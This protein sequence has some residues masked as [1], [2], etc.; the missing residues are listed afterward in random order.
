MTD[1]LQQPLDL[2]C[3]VSVPNR[4]AKAAMTEGLATS[5][6]VATPE[7]EQLY[8]LWSDGGAG[9]LLSGN[10]QVDAAHLERP[11]NVVIER[12]PDAAMAKALASWASAA[13]RNGNHFWGQISHAGRQTQKMVNPHP[14]APSAIKLD[15]P[16][17]QFGVPVPLTTAEIAD[18]VGRF[19]TC[20][21]ALQVAGFTGVQVHAAHGYLLSQFLSPLS[22]LRDDEYGGNLANRARILLEIISE[23]RDAVGPGF[24]VA[25]KLN[26]ADF[27]K[28]GFDF[29]DSLQV[30]GWLEQAG[31][32]LIEISGG[33]YEQPKLLGVEGIEEE[34]SQTVAESTL[35][36]EAY[37]VDFAKAMQAK[38]AIPLMVTGGFRRRDIMTQCLT[39][40]DV[41]LIGIGRPM[42]VLTDAPARIFGGLD[43]L[44]RY[45]AQLSLLPPWLSG[46]N[47]LKTLRVMGTFAVQYWF[48]AQ[49]DLLG[50]TGKADPG[51]S[52]MQATR[53]M[54]ALQKKQLADR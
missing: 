46:L 5:A 43:T 38:V 2:P 28:G 22:N 29:E 19:G 31:V 30:A 40:G 45:E 36:R 42:C 8:G 32:D 1:L 26:S 13:T 11:G 12:E 23:V 14:K 21:R 15:L 44:P 18:I 39:A 41:D 6:G 24:P 47:R 48:Y 52:V 25:V 27:Q 50:T 7:L 17:G 54:M 34:E 49:L 20:A 3:G 16:G 51:L 4:L 53:R 10:I 35:A 9:L 37:F 33:T